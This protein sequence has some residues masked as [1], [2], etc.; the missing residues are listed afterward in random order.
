MK[1]EIS[2]TEF[3]S[4][5]KV[6]DK[7]KD[8]EFKTASDIIIDND[9]I[10]K[11]NS[12][13][14]IIYIM[15]DNY[16][17]ENGKIILP[18]QTAE[19]IKKLKEDKFTLSDGKIKTDKKEISFTEQNNIDTNTYENIDKIFE[20]TQRELLRMLEVNYAMAQDNT[21]PILCGV[22][23][24]KNETCALDGYRMS[25][26]V[27]EQYKSDYS[28]IVNKDSID[29]LKSILKDNDNIVNVYYD[30]KNI[31]KFEID[32]IILI[33]KC[34]EGEFIKYSQIIP[35]EHS[36]KSI[37]EPEELIEELEFIKSA[38]K[39][40]YIKN[41]FSENKITLKGSQCKEVYNEDKSYKEQS[42]KQKELD[43]EYK[44]KHKNWISKNKKGKEPKQKSAKFIKFSD[45][46]PMNE[47]KSEINAENKLDKY[48]SENGEFKI[49]Y[50]PNYMVEGLKQ[51]SDK[52]ELRMTSSVSP[53]IITNNG[54]DLE[55][56]LPVRL[57]S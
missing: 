16:I 56:V 51:Y 25:I 37:L 40:N 57:C 31:V 8:K 41:V 35:N 15:K 20:V 49:A 13:T 3:K 50:N 23:F 4:M 27:S 28:F 46:I 36:H 1:T 26:R 5:L 34:L 7:I 9:K 48:G 32:N 47:I 24:N 30:T 18:S 33:A 55:L 44:D 39:K 11:T 45:L 52:V 43:E 10:I 21:R 19:L 2:T 42:K 53:I 14:T 12:Q 22:Y 6:I 29:I 17:Q 38:D 54:N